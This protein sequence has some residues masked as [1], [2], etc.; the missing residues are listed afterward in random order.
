MISYNK[1]ILALLLIM[2]LS[3]TRVLAW[4]YLGNHWHQVR[5]ECTPKAGQMIHRFDTLPEGRP[6][7]EVPSWVQSVASPTRSSVR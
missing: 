6:A 4:G 7:K 1:S 2:L 5:M 3:S